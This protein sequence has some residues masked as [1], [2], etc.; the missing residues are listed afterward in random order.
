MFEQA[1][2]QVIAVGLITGSELVLFEL[3]EWYLD[4]QGRDWPAGNYRAQ[5]LA[6]GIVVED[7]DGRL[8]AETPDLTLKPRD[9]AASFVIREVPIG[10]DFHWEQRL[11]QEFTGILRIRSTADRQ[12][13]VI[14]EVPVEDYLVSVISSEMSATADP[15]MLRAHATIS[16]SWL[17][18]QLARRSAVRDSPPTAV[19]PHRTLPLTELIRWY[20]RENHDNFDV[21][22][23]D[24]CQRYQGI[25]TATTTAAALAVE[26]THGM[27]LCSDGELCDARFS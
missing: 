24:H 8:I 10:I 4:D 15:E 13:T 19:A 23:D 21:C 5:P 18:A 14:N 20:D 25:T 7:L 16:R 1:C 27:V 26:A 12:L 3:K 11:D 6:G 2:E 22:A 17:L 9:V